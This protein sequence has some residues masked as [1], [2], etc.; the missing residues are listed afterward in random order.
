[1]LSRPWDGYDIEPDDPYADLAG[2]WSAFYAGARTR[3]LDPIE[4]A[5]AIEASL[6]DGDTICRLV[7]ADAVG[8][9]AGR[10]R[11]GDEGWLRYG[12]AQTDDA[13]F[14]RLASDFGS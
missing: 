13:W 8:F 3:S 4:V 1:M 5:K 9:V 14:R 6:V 10:E 12:D 2:K 7:G 11:I